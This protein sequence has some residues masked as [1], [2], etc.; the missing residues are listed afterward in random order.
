MSSLFSL[1][2]FLMSTTT[3][4]DDNPTLILCPIFRDKSFNQISGESEICN[5]SA[6]LEVSGKLNFYWWT[7]IGPIDSSGLFKFSFP[8]WF[9][10]GVSRGV[11]RESAIFFDQVAS[12]ENKP[13]FSH[14]ENQNFTGFLMRL[15]ACRTSHPQHNFRLWRIQTLHGSRKNFR[16]VITKNNF[17]NLRPTENRIS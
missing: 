4:L 9:H 6:I 10:K 1:L 12:V 14:R 15:R 3:M 11:S 16:Y 5:A 2:N 13:F 17:L 7:W 8:N